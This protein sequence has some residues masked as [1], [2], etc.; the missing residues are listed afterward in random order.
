MSD[1][2]T[3]ERRRT[4]ALAIL[5]K[6]ERLTRKSGSFLGQLI[7]DPTPMSTAQQ[8]W[9]SVLVERAGLAPDGGANG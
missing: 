7:V 8:D 2:Y 9:F 5:T 4:M 3:F 1:G 6:G